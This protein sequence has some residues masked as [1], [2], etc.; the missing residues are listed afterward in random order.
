MGTEI[1]RKFIVVGEAWRCC[2]TRSVRM[3]QGYLTQDARRVVRV[4]ATD[5]RGS[6]TLK[7][8]SRGAA[9]TEFEYEIPTQDAYRLLDELCL[10][11]LI[12]KTRYCVPHGGMVWEIDEFHAPRPGLI[13]AEIEIP[14]V[15][16]EVERPDWVGD[17]VTGNPL[18]YNHNMI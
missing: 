6:L 13:L 1:E 5:D 4:R 15:D 12:E 11:P 14:S 10:K 7:G 8:L 16:F 17:E 2:S 3:V 9:R 18:F